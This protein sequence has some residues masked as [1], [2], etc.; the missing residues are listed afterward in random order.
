[1]AIYLRYAI[2]S[3]LVLAQSLVAVDPARAWR[4]FRPGPENG[5]LNDVAVDGAGHVV[6]TGKLNIV[7]FDLLM[8]I[9]VDGSDGQ[10]VWQQSLVGSGGPSDQ[11]RGDAVEVDSSGDVVVAG[12]IENV[13]T[14]VDF[15]VAKLDGVTGAEVWRAELDG[16]GAEPL[17]DLATDV[18]LDSSGDVIAVGQLDNGV[19]ATDLTVV[20]LDGAT[21][22]E[23]WR[24]SVDGAFAGSEDTA[25]AVAITASDDVVVAGALEQADEDWVF[26]V[27]RIDGAS[28][29]ESWRREIDT[30]A[31]V[32][33]ANHV[34]LTSSGDVVAA[35]ILGDGAG[36]HDAAVVR[37]DG[38]TGAEIW[39][40]LAAGSDDGL[41][42]IESVAVDAADDVVAVGCV[43]N[44]GSVATDLLAWKVDGITGADVWRT[45]LR[46]TGKNKDGCGRDVVVDASG[47]VYAAG[48]LR[49]SALGAAVVKLD[50]GTGDEQ[51]RSVQTISGIG[52]SIALDAAGDI[53]SVGDLALSGLA[54]LGITHLTAA[55]GI[56]G[57]LE[58]S[59]L[60]VKDN[61]SDA[62]KRKI[63]ATLKDLQI[64]TPAAGAA[65][66][67]TVA[68]ATVRLSNPGT[69]ESDTIALPP[70]PSWK[71]KGKPPGA[72]GYRYSGP[73]A[74]SSLK[75]IPGKILKL[76]CS[77]KKGAIGFSLDE[78]S[79]GELEISVQLGAGRSQCA[80]FGGDVT[81]DFGTSNPG[82]PGLFRA[83]KAPAAAGAC[84]SP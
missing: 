62:T 43:R 26:T 71:A 9:K 54:K 52:H 75:I 63:V 18:A 31:N 49:V 22:A 68:G 84:G 20:K 77:G 3:A 80:R 2:V 48:M 83:R 50:G 58:G 27:L 72:K 37:L 10:E 7:P 4:Y 73:G 34:E 32:A 76:S 12:R 47:D 56:V 40:A 74:C 60:V 21:G 28:G 59:Q 24:L 53:V 38:A 51:W 41:D 35:G 16:V 81:L 39:R 42:W 57:P 69:G 45:D 30:I 78:A 11:T 61:A 36:G 65:N 14:D 64:A 25:T 15:F 46:G 1:M 5:S 66:D 55:D 8:V 29:A 6:A 67:P 23:Q 13:A 82:P 44:S 19:S 70:G 79:Q 17:D 33:R